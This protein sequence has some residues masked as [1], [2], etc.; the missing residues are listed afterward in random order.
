MSEKRTEVKTYKCD[1][2]CDDC[3]EPMK[4]TGKSYLTYPEQYEHKCPN[5]HRQTFIVI[6]PRMSYDSIL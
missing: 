1:Y 3:N 6:Y 2:L 5:E 4:F